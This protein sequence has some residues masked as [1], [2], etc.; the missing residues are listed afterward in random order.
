MAAPNLLALATVY[1]DT[2]VLAA[3]ATETDLIAA[4]AT[5]KAVS[6][7]AIYCANIH[8]TDSGWVTVILTKTAVNRTITYQQRIQVKTTINPLLGRPLYL[9]EGDSLR[10]TAN[11]ASNVYVTAP[12]SIMN[13]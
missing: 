3:T 5:G 10:I 13:V 6:V 11:A 7:E 9:A 4:V 12:Y 8:A 2:A 1:I